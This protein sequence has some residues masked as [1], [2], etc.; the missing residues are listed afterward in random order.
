MANLQKT[1][2]RGSNRRPSRPTTPRLE[3]QI[4][5]H[6]PDDHS[7]YHGHE[8]LRSHSS[9]DDE[10]AYSEE[11]HSHHTGEEDSRSQHSAESSSSSDGS[12]DQIVDLEKGKSNTVPEVRDGI[13]DER[14]IPE[15]SEKSEKPERLPR[16]RRKSTRSERDLNLVSLKY[17][18]P[19]KIKL[20]YT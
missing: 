15:K 12:G 9:S 3:R 19:I 20:T 10:S 4:S 18:L 5:L 14:D 6:Y 2:S 1:A 16:P 13:A 8:S 17:C 11:T 7:V